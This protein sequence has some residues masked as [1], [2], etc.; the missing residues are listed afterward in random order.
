MTKLLSTAVRFGSKKGR[1]VLKQADQYQNL[2]WI[3]IMAMVASILWMVSI[4][5]QHAGGTLLSGTIFLLWAILIGIA[6]TKPSWITKFAILPGI[7]GLFDRDAK[8]DLFAQ[9]AHERSPV[10][11][12]GKLTAEDVG[13]V[14]AVK[15]WWHAVGKIEVLWFAHALPLVFLSFAANPASYAAIV[16]GAWLFYMTTER[17]SG[18]GRHPLKLFGIA[19]IIGGAIGMI[20]AH[21][22]GNIAERESYDAV[23]GQVT[24]RM[25]AE[26]HQLRP[27][28]PADAVYDSITGEKLVPATPEVIE[29]NQAWFAMEKVRETASSAIES[30]GRLSGPARD[31]ELTELIPAR[32]YYSHNLTIMRVGDEFTRWMRPET[33]YAFHVRSSGT[34]EK[35]CFN[36]PES[37]ARFIRVWGTFPNF[38]VKLRDGVE[39]K[40]VTFRAITERDRRC[41]P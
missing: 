31:P 11:Y 32:E 9:Q 41:S 22:W 14:S 37:E 15:L 39:E 19:L 34:R 24:L 25:T 8:I 23:T 29:A 20:P 27:D 33:E 16:F 38:F 2:G 12:R 7:Y 6:G 21:V 3:A 35:V 1:K 18:W 10:K 40:P 30:L 4:N 13:F 28:A 17:L 26:T 36:G 5:V